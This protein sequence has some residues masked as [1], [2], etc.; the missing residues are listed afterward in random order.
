MGDEFIL[1]EKLFFSSPTLT[2]A[3]QRLGLHQL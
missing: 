3:S 2:G 1:A